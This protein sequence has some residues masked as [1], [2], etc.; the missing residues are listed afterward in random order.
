MRKLKKLKA[1]KNFAIK[2]GLFCNYENYF[3]SHIIFYKGEIKTDKD[4]SFH[5]LL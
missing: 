2:N 4:I 3:I 5:I 1:M